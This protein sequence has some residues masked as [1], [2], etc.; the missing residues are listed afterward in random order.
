MA[1]LVQAYVN[2]T[3]E[4]MREDAAAS[5]NTM[6]NRHENGRV[7]I[8]AIEALLHLLYSAPIAKERD[9][10]KRRLNRATRMKRP[11]PL[12]GAFSP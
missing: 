7:R 3:D 2:K 11:K 12:A 9:R 10:F 4:I 5:T 8:Q 6:H 1:L